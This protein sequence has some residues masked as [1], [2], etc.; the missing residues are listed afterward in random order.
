M[1]SSAA[2]LG[3]T[4]FAQLCK[5]IEKAGHDEDADACAEDVA[6]L[7]DCFDATIGAL[8]ALQTKAA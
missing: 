6:Q 7:R 5:N 3:A 8:Q 2:Y 4:D 1:K